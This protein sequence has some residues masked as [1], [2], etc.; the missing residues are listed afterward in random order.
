MKFLFLIMS[1]TAHRFIMFNGGKMLFNVTWPIEDDLFKIL[2]LSAM[3]LFNSVFDLY[4]NI[5]ETR[6]IQIL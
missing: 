3:R 4:R 5:F 1:N 2:I 6:L